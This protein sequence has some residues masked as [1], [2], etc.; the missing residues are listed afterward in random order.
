MNDD[1]VDETEYPVPHRGRGNPIGWI[2]II[3][4]IAASAAGI[5]LSYQTAGTVG[6]PPEQRE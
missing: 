6:L 1:P 4:L 2:I 5:I 3:C